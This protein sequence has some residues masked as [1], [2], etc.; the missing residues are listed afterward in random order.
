MCLA[1]LKERGISL[2]SRVAMAGE[3]TGDYQP[4]VSRA[5]RKLERAVFVISIMAL[6]Q[7]ISY[8][9]TEGP[10]SDCRLRGCSTVTLPTQRSLH[11]VIES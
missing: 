4:M 6:R 5:L 10:C 11:L 8:K 2:S 3:Y 9:E 1:A 7:L